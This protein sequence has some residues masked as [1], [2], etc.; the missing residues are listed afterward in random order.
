MRSSSE[1]LPSGLLCN[2]YNEISE[3][4]DMKIDLVDLTV[5]LIVG[6]CLLSA[7]ISYLMGG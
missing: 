2:E 3:G 7:G 1:S 5:A 4:R 6:V